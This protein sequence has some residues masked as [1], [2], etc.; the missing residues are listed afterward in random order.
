MPKKISIRIDGE[1][2]TAPEG[3]TI[4]EAARAASRIV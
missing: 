3:Q 4:L 1:L 2:V